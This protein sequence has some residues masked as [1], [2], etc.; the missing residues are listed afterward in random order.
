MFLKYGS[1]EIKNLKGKH[2]AEEFLGF[3]TVS[4]VTNSKMC[5]PSFIC[6]IFTLGSCL[7]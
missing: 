2:S 3:I 1:N 6:L 5:S 7:H 4:H